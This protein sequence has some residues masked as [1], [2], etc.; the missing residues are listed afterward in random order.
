M[1]IEITINCDSDAFGD[2]PLHE[3]LR[4]LKD[5]AD[6]TWGNVGEVVTFMN[7]KAIIR[8]SNGNTVGRICW[9]A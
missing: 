7:D 3:V 5:M 8:D 6:D 2:E 4:I 1:H 9:V